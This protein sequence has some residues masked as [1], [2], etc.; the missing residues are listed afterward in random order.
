MSEH[1]RISNTHRIQGKERNKEKSR[2]CLMTVYI[3]LAFRR[4]NTY[5]FIFI[6]EFFGCEMSKNTSSIS[7]IYSNKGGSQLVHNGFVFKLNK[8]TST[9]I[10]WKCT[11]T[12]CTA[13]IHTDTNNNLLNTIGEHNHFL[14][15][16]E[17]EIKKFRTILKER[18]INETVPI[19]KIIDEEITKA[20]F[21]QE[22]LASVP[23]A[24]H[25]RMSRIVQF[26][27]LS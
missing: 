14:E 4:S 23:L 10:Y 1:S 7:F 3:S 17:L 12:N 25:I 13:R 16:E 11:V 24:H 26:S 18:A 19:Q 22:T 15:P 20:N 21:S 6:Y 5:F 27:N 8:S 2:Y 9:K